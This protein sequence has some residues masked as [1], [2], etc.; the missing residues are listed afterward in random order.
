MAF[1]A[2]ALAPGDKVA[3]EALAQAEFVQ[4]EAPTDWK[5]DEVYIFECWATWCGPCI[6]VIPHVDELFDKYHEQGLNIYGMNV[7]EDGKDKAAKFVEKKGE[8]MSYPV[9]Y[10]G[11]GGAFEESWL[12]P[13]GVRGIPHAFVVKNGKLLFSTHPAGLK[14]DLIVALLAGGDQETAAVKAIRDEEANKAAMSEAVKAF[15]TAA[16]QED[17]AGMQAAL[18]KVKE[19]SPDAPYLDAMMIDLA[20]TKKEWGEVEKLISSSSESRQGAMSA[21]NLAMKLESS[22]EEIPASLRETIIKVLEQGSSASVF[23]YPIIAHMHFALGDKEKAQAAAKKLLGVDERLPVEINEAFV[24]SFDTDEPQ[25]IMEFRKA[26]TD[27]MRKQAAE[28]KAA[29][30]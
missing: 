20:T 26:L 9:A 28:K 24:A 17:V 10:V 13:A 5:S 23:D 29:S 6:A 25:T 18:E 21:R 8:G 12:K 11:K 1:P 3:I 4:G 22:E 27:A 15:Q 19:L 2:M 30:E 14:E 16:G 7:W